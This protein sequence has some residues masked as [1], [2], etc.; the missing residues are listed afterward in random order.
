MKDGAQELGFSFAEC[1]GGVGGADKV[2]GRG[3]EAGG[4]LRE[5][6]RLSRG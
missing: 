1:Y 2:G 4:I 3:G 6:I 5:G